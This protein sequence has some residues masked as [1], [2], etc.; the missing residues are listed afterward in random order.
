MKHRHI[1]AGVEGIVQLI[2]ASY[3]R[4][5]YYWYVTGYVPPRKD[6]AIVDRKL[7]AKYQIDASEW[8]RTRR[9]KAGIANAQYVRLDQWFILMVTEGHHPLK[10]TT[11]NG[12]EGSQ[13]KDVRR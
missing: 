12:G 3:L 8:E 11:D 1:A 10:Q 13:L 2:A 6:P 9:R 4:H 5:G 7:V